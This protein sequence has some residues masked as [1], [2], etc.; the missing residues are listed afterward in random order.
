MSP[1]RG[2]SDLR[3]RIVVKS[4][5]DRR[6]IRDLLVWLDMDRKPFSK[7]GGEE[8]VEMAIRL[9]RIPP[10]ILGLGRNFGL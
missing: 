2:C 1:F 6:S 4:G 10:A 3:L 9:G 8:M 7:R 5:F